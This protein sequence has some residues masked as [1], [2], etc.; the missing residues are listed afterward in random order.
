M[1]QAVIAIT[2]NVLV[3]VLV[4]LS[5]RMDVMDAQILFAIQFWSYIQTRAQ[6][7]LGLHQ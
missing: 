1:Y 6:A 4:A 3:H 2:P 5:V 7:R